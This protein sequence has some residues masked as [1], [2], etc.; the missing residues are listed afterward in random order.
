MIIIVKIYLS[1]LH[2]VSYMYPFK[3]RE[4]LYALSKWWIQYIVP[5]SDIY[6]E[7]IEQDVQFKTCRIRQGE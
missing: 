6:Y 3:F 4:V 2:V 7:I 1:M 5:T